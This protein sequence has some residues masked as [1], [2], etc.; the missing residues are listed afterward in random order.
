MKKVIQSKY[1]NQAKSSRISDAGQ[2]NAGS[3]F[4]Q[5]QTALH[6]PSNDTSNNSQ[7]LQQQPQQP[8]F[9]FGAQSQQ[10]LLNKPLAESNWV[11]VQNAVTVPTNIMRPNAISVANQ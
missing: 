8:I 7:Q 1:A 11:P 5:A 3:V 9:G 10:S 4:P 6:A 2:A